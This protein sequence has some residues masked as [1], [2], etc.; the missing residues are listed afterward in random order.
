MQKSDDYISYCD[1]S[2]FGAG[3]IWFGSE[4]QLD[5]SVWRIVWPVDIQTAVVSESN[6]KGRLT[7]SDL[8]MVGILLH[9]LVLKLPFG[10]LQRMN[11]WRAPVCCPVDCRI[12]LYF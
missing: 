12:R 5:R 6:P 10:S 8:E 11:G 4:R 1:A 7:N 9:V 2:A 3:G